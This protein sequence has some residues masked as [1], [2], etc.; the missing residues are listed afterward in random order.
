MPAKSSLTNEQIDKLLFYIPR[1]I[2]QEEMKESNTLS[3]EDLILVKN[4]AEEINVSTS[5]VVM[6]KNY[7]YAHGIDTLAR[8]RCITKTGP[9]QVSEACNLVEFALATGLKAPQLS[10]LFRK[11]VAAKLPLWLKWRNDCGHPFIEAASL[12]KFFPQSNGVIKYYPTWKVEYLDKL[13]R[14]AKGVSYEEALTAHEEHLKATR[15][16]YIYLPIRTLDDFQNYKAIDPSERD[17]YEIIID[18]VTQQ[19]SSITDSTLSELT[20]FGLNKVRD[21][22]LFIMFHG[23]EELL[24]Y[25]S[26]HYPVPPTDME[27]SWIMDFHE[28]TSLPLDTT[29]IIFKV[30]LNRLKVED[31]R[32]KQEH[33]KKLYPPFLANVPNSTNIALLDS[34]IAA[35]NKATPNVTYM[36]LADEFYKQFGT[37]A[38]DATHVAAEILL[39]ALES[40]KH[41]AHTIDEMVDIKHK[42]LDLQIGYADPYLYSVIDYERMRKDEYS[43][44]VTSMMNRST[45]SAC[46]PVIGGDKDPSVIAR[47]A[48][49]RKL[50]QQEEQAEDADEQTDQQNE[51]AKKSKGK[52]GRMPVSTKRKIAAYQKEQDELFK[53]W[54][55]TP[56]NFELRWEGFKF[57]NKNFSMPLDWTAPMSCESARYV[58]IYD[59]D[60]EVPQ[61]KILS[62]EEKHRFKLRGLK[63]SENSDFY[64]YLSIDAHVDEYDRFVSTYNGMTCTIDSFDL[65]TKLTPRLA[66]AK[67]QRDYAD[68]NTLQ[69]RMES[70]FV[71]GTY[72]GSFFQLDSAVSNAGTSDERIDITTVV[73]RPQVKIKRNSKVRKANKQ[74]KSF[75]QEIQ[76][77]KGSE[78]EKLVFADVLLE[79]DDVVDKRINKAITKEPLAAPVAFAPPEAQ[80]DAQTSN[81][82]KLPVTNDKDPRSEFVS[83]ILHQKF[84]MRIDGSDSMLTQTLESVV[85]QFEA[86][87]SSTELQE[88]VSEVVAKGG[89]VKDLMGFLRQEILDELGYDIGIS[90]EE[91][92]QRDYSRG[93]RPPHVNPYDPRFNELPEPVRKNSIKDYAVARYTAEFAKKI[94]KSISVPVKN[95]YYRADRTCIRVFIY[96][97]IV[98]QMSWD[99][100]AC[101]VAHLL[102]LNPGV[103]NYHNKHRDRSKCLRYQKHDRVVKAMLAHAAKYPNQIGALEFKR[104]LGVK[105][106]P[107]TAKTAAKLMKFLG[108]YYVRSHRRK[109]YST[110]QGCNAFVVPNRAKGKFNPNRPFARINT[111]I[112]FIEVAEGIVVIQ[113]FNDDFNDEIRVA[114]FGQDQSLEAVLKPLKVLLNL[115]PK[116]ARCMIHTDRGWQYLHKDYAALLDND[117]RTIRSMSGLGICQHNATCERINGAFKEYLASKLKGAEPTLANVRKH[118]IDFVHYYNNERTNKKADEMPPVY[119]MNAWLKRQVRFE[120]SITYTEIESSSVDAA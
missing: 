111:D 69:E 37:N 51:T 109:K 57:S 41:D 94:I 62:E 113:F 67:Y 102:K 79:S 58:H 64:G 44:I 114:S 73:C 90:V 104:H 28:A 63:V 32:R 81:Q 89:T 74:T 19:N 68:I 82:A 106:N 97:L 8:K 22:R 76:A 3:K 101:V 72:T 23:A 35:A 5:V 16:K 13:V 12:K 100:R 117:S 71:I 33:G 24:S 85:K 92:M 38:K 53:R 26:L 91:Y 39:R 93:G 29:A 47:K 78:E 83:S 107:T 80:F 120:E 66:K 75:A 50:E 88:S 2:E 42:A 52:K 61:Q 59:W 27:I 119:K 34:K 98:G 84:G 54:G 48:I 65:V 70:S 112:T 108:I 7:A 25:P 110:Y 99:C 18:A 56:A 14:E 95:I 118:F 45:E 4:V 36:S 31:V 86:I 20:G 11:S 115:M 60:A 1:L 87:V 30:P 77:A 116:D 21:I 105:G 17:P 55:S 9:L 40:T 15:A 49:E 6:W 103:I 46:A 96:N 10:A 43:I